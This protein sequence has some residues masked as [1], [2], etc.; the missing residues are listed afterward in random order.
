VP[1]E[2]L[3]S[4]PGLQEVHQ[5]TLVAKLGITGLQD[6][7]NANPRA[8]HTALEKVRP[9]SSLTRIAAW[10][11]TARN[12]LR[13]PEADASDWHTAAS[14]A[15]VFAQRQVDGGWERRLEAEQ[16]EVEPAP[17]PWQRAGWDCAPLCDWMLG[18]LGLTEDDADSEA[19]VADQT[20]A[21]ATEEAASA[22]EHETAGEPA[23]SAEERAAAA[24]EPAPGAE[25][26]ETERATLR[27]D[28]AT[29]TDALHK[30]ELIREG[31]VI[32]AP[33]EEV[34][35]PVQLSFTVSG[36]RSGQQL[37]AAVWFRGRAEPG[38]SPHEPVTI[39]PSRQ[40][41]FNLSSVPPGGHDIRLLAW[42]TDPGATLAAVT[43]PRMI[44]LEEEQ[45]DGDPVVAGS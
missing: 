10:Q 4:I 8:I 43:L 31:S 17:E 6:L 33:P 32:A 1:G 19:V 38:W 45:Q 12:R 15:V 27:I 3:T 42:A 2:D 16:T 9:Y 41:E 40:A 18:Q 5:R 44:F 7:V 36:A 29:M 37:R 20:G 25:P 11:N 26:A 28:S 13:D 22:E 30:L 21:A 39:P 34:R 14:F 35:H 24:E 23:A